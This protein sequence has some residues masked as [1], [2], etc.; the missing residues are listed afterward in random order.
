MDEPT[1]SVVSM[2]RKEKPTRVREAPIATIACRVGLMSEMA[3]LQQ[4]NTD[5]SC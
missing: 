1:P 4:L 2:Y 3:I 5:W